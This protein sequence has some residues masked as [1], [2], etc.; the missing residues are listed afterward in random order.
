[1]ITWIPLLAE[2]KHL[3]KTHFQHDF[4]KYLL[5]YWTACKK[6][7]IKK[8][9]KLHLYKMQCSKKQQHTPQTIKSMVLIYASNQVLMSRLCFFFVFVFVLFVFR[10]ALNLFLC[11][12]QLSLLVQLKP[13]IFALFSSHLSDN[14]GFANIFFCFLPT[15]QLFK[16]TFFVGI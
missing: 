7:K 9:Q 13:I 4:L 11:S 2:N 15:Q 14:T 1:M 3:H 16:L 5:K 12:F 10:F 6:N 8:K